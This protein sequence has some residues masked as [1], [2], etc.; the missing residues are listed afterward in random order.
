M[1]ALNGAPPG[2]GTRCPTRSKSQRASQTTQRLFVRLYLDGLATNDFEPV[3]RAVVSPTTALSAFSCANLPH[4][5][6]DVMEWQA[7]AAM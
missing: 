7:R 2:R 5:S 3:F 4:R 6:V 1:E